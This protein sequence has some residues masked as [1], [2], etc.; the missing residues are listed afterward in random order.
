MIFSWMVQGY[1]TGSNNPDLDQM[2]YEQNGRCFDARSVRASRSQVAGQAIIQLS[3]P[4]E[5]RGNQ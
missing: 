4:V 5:N 2:H 3:R 1:E